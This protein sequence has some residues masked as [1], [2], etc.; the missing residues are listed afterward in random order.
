MKKIYKF[1][2]KYVLGISLL[3]LLI[4]KVG[5]SSII[6]VLKEL[7]WYY[8]PLVIV[9]WICLFILGTL[10][11]AILLKPLKKKI[12]KLKLFSYYILSWSFGLF[13]PGKIGEFALVYFLKKE[14]LDI[15]KGLVI[16][17]IDKIITIFSLMMISSFGLLMYLKFSIA[18]KLIL[19]MVAIFIILIVL[20]FSNFSRNII[21]KY[22]LRKY[23][24][25]FKNFSNILKTYF[26][27]HKT[28]L[29]LNLL[30][31]FL[32]WIVSAL[33][34]L[35]LFNALDQAVPFIHV[36]L[37]NAVV[38]IIALIPITA[39]GLGIKEYS[40]VYLFSLIGINTS[41]TAGAYILGAI[42]VYLIALASVFIFRIEK[43]L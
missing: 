11:I 29:F 32:K 5:L 19:L 30:V 28:V 16:S 31:T 36:F 37:L 14:K 34:I 8:I 15:A 12:N 2:I 17:L 1:S 20:I 18:I 43:H 23:A 22:I 39:N 42:L 6:S 40:A 24:I 41:I 21:K 3:L 35:L 9:T 26:K 4:Y 7:N 38:T 10:N 25:K 27:K 33:G 13:I